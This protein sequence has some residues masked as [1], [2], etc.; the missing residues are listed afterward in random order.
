ML[1][2]FYTY[3]D[4]FDLMTKKIILIFENSKI[5]PTLNSEVNNE[6]LIIA[7]NEGIK[8]E[9]TNLGYT[10]KLINN[11]SK[12]P[13]NELN[14]AIQWVKNWPDKPI[15]NG[16]NFKDL[17]VYDE[18]S[19]FW[20]LES[21]FFSYRIQNL[22]PLIEQIKNMIKIENPTEIFIQ[23]NSDL[24]NIIKKKYGNTIQKIYF[25]SIEKEDSRTSYKS[26]SGNR[27]L[28]LL[29]LKFFRGIDIFSKKDQIT[30]NPILIITEMAY[31]RPDYD[32]DEKK[33]IHKDTIFHEVIKNL[34]ASNLPIRIIDFENK[35]KRLLKSN[36]LKNERQKTLGAT[37]EPWENYI[38]LEIIK[39]TKKYNHDLE[40]LWKKLKNSEE[41]EKS[42]TYDDIPLYDILKNDIE[43]LLKTFKSY[44][45]IT[46]IETAK[47][48]LDGIKPSIILMHD[49]YGTLQLSIIKEAKKR[50]IPT[51]SIQHGSNTES[52]ISYV[53]PKHHI[54]DETNNLNFPLPQKI[55]VWSEK[56]KEDLIKSGNFPDDIPVITGDPKI[57]FLPYAIT[58]FNQKNICKKLK[59]PS[60]KKIIVYAT[61]PFANI[62]EKELITNSIFRSIKK[63]D[64]TFLLIKVHPNEDNLSFYKEIAEKFKVTNYSI[65]Q[66]FNLYEIL[67]IS[68]VVINAYS[69]VGIEAMRMKKPVIS[70]DMFG[71]HGNDPLIKSGIS[72]VVN[73]E[74]QLIPAIKNCFKI[75]DIDKIIT[76]RE[77]FAE[78]EI[79]KVD[80]QASS[81]IF[82]LILELK[83]NNTNI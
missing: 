4:N 70:L 64:D 69:T 12:N 9:I 11:Y 71:L 43:F 40:Q 73:S 51:I 77:L 37:V 30:K 47:R 79:G 48:I 56:S 13:K 49:E 15:L 36:F 76:E 41:F 32:Y 10:C 2:A 55:C 62:Q 61:Q 66:F 54:R 42:L 82:N 26:Y 21:R 58:R 72:I 46:F 19:I 83:K 67:F 5:E 75:K 16:K 68:D 23:G 1:N 80:G 74:T 78:R 60:E 38:N 50:N 63:L 20:F 14:A 29:A 7:G 81:R 57:D 6:S 59:I 34:K 28:K 8:D 22:I 24:H 27:F 31:W 25:K 3:K 33:I 35:P 18:L 52:S 53:H 39:K 65:Q 44:M 45:S 17:L